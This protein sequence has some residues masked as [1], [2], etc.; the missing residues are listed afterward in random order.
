MDVLMDNIAG[1]EMYSIMD[2]N[3]GYN[4]V[5]ICPNDVEKTAFRTPIGN[6]YYLVMS[7]GLKNAGATYQR[8]MVAIFHDFIHIY[9]EIYID[10]I[11]VK[12]RTRL[13]HFDVLRKSSTDAVYTN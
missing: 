2:G 3:S 10:E 11:V 9:I 7:F 8:V 1:C 5:S 6:F 12:S 13:G 4:Q